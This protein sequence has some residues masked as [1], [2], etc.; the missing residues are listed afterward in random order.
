MEQTPEIK[1]PEINHKRLYGQFNREII[2]KMRLLNMEVEEEPYNLEKVLEYLKDKKQREEKKFQDRD[3][4][5]AEMFHEWI[6]K[7][8][9]NL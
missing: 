5:K 7:N 2:D 1:K 4:M 8:N 3:A 9:I 6:L